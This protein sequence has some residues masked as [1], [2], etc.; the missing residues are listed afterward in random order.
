[1]N[2]RSR[3]RFR[4][5]ADTRLRSAVHLCQSFFRDLQNQLFRFNESAKDRLQQKDLRQALFAGVKE[6]VNKIGLDARAAC[7]KKAHEYLGEAGLLMQPVEHLIPVNL[8]RFAVRHGGC[9]G[10]MQRASARK[11]RLSNE[12]PRSEKGNGCFMAIFGNNS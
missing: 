8:E 6:P 5:K 12:V 4:E 3:K 11:R 2:P 9:S 7:K 1:M 10:R